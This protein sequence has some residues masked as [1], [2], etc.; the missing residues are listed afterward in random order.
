MIYLYSFIMN[1]CFITYFFDLIYYNHWQLLL[2]VTSSHLDFNIRSFRNIY[3]LL[4]RCL[5]K[6]S[7]SF[8]SCCAWRSWR[9]IIRSSP[10][11]GVT[12]WEALLASRRNARP[13]QILIGW[14]HLFGKKLVTWK[15]CYPLFSRAYQKKSELRPA[16]C[17]LAAMFW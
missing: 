12:F 15:P 14:N 4:E 6:T 5:R 2:T 16:G 3:L 10:M 7:W 1:H 17:S 13:S 9:S 11:S 8:R